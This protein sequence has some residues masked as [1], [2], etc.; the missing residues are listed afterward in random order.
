MRTLRYLPDIRDQL[1]LLP[2]TARTKVKA[3]LEDLAH[4][5]PG[6]DVRRLRGEFRKPLQRLKVG[7]WRVVFYEDGGDLLVV[8]IFA[9]MQGYDWLAAWES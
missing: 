9:R 8:R 4:A 6:V 1:R 7:T 2:P 5:K 3:G